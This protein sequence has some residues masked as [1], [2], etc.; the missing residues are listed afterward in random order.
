MKKKDKNREKTGALGFLIKGIA[1]CAFVSVVF[2]V[3][4]FFFFIPYLNIAAAV[5][6]TPTCTT[7]FL[8]FFHKSTRM[9][10]LSTRLVTAVIT[11]P[12]AYL[13]IC[14]MTGTLSG[15]FGKTPVEAVDMRYTVVMEYIEQ[16]SVIL[17]NAVFYIS[18]P[19]Q[20]MQDLAAWGIEGWFVIALAAIGAQIGIPQFFIHRRSLP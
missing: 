3:A 7:V 10:D 5:V 15:I 13:H 12:C 2:A 16:W 9:E 20:L 1:A 11:L 6:L 18:T 19:A 4:G 17:R 8:R 14:V